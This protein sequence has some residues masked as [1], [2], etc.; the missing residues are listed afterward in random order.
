MTKKEVY[1]AHGIELWKD[2]LV[3]PVG[4]ITPILQTGNTKTGAS[5]YTSSLLAGTK[6]WNA[7]VDGVQT[8]VKG[9]CCCNC[10]GCYAQCGRYNAQNVIDAL[11]ARTILARDHVD[12]MR[13]AIIAQIIADKIDTIRIHAAGE[14]LP[15]NPAYTQAW[16]DISIASPSVQ[17]WSYTKNKDAENAFDNVSNCNIVKSIIPGI[18]FN[19]GHCD[20]ILSAYNALK[21]TGA[22]VHICKCGFDKNQHCENCRGCI[23]N[24][25]VLFIEH[26]TDYKASADPL[27][28]VLYQIAMAA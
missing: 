21:K 10:E 4:L 20:H 18:G 17:L 7:N 16:K 15:E 25:F 27:Y 9:T 1:A 26:S 24:D 14:F 11:A 5:V 28:P 3:T 2:K 22:K 19:F 8:C 13:D 6:D 23:E 12:F